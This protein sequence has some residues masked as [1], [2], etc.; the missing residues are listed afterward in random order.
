MKYE[1]GD[2]YYKD[3]LHD[4]SGFLKKARL[5]QSTFRAVKL[6]VN[7]DKYG[8]YLT[9]D[10]ARQGLNFYNDF[11]IFEEVRKRYP[12]YSKPL[13][14][15]MLRSEHIGFNLF[16]PFKTNPEYGKQVLNEIMSGQIAFID[17]IEIEYAPAPAEKYLNDKTSFDAYV[18]YTHIDGQKG[19]IGI[20]IKYTEREYAL[21]KDSKQAR[22]IENKNS[23]Y[24]EV[25]TKSQLYKGGS[26]ESLISDKFRQVWRNQLLGESMLQMDKDKFQHFSSMTL[27]PKGNTHF[28]ACSREYMDML[29]VNENR[30]VPVC[31]EDFLNACEIHQPSERFGK[32]I[33]YMRERYIVADQNEAEITNTIMFSKPWGR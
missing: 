15:N 17:R 27:F 8:N 26:T 2:Q 23:R 19:I 24:Y 31:Y 33:A 22:D 30:F 5:H 16:V 3:R 1:I 32:W 9:E 7:F 18:E 29:V 20:E 4:S 10:D 6:N 28:V 21:K 13:Y 14:A 25:S 12:N 11:E